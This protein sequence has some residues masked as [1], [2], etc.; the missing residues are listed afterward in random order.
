M[1][2]GSINYKISKNKYEIILYIIDY[3]EFILYLAKLIYFFR[4]F[5]EYE[6]FLIENDKT[7]V[8][9]LYINDLIEEIPTY[10]RKKIFPYW[11]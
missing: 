5:D 10:N 6:L 8:D 4:D 11:K 3:D 1:A 9:W 2:V 7:E